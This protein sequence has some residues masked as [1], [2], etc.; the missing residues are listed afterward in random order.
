MYSVWP[1]LTSIENTKFSWQVR[2]G[3]HPL[4]SL[5]TIHP[6]QEAEEFQDRKN[7]RA[8]GEENMTINEGFPGHSSTDNSKEEPEKNW[9][10]ILL[11]QHKRNHMKNTESKKVTIRHHTTSNHHIYVYNSTSHWKQTHQNHAK[12]FNEKG[13]NSKNIHGANPKWAWRLQPPKGAFSAFSRDLATSCR[14][15]V[16]LRQDCVSQIWSL[17]PRI[18]LMT[19]RWEKDCTICIE[20]VTN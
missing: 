19:Q 16:D 7:M 9:M 15:Q 8:N 14:S 2:C 10:I 13:D 20:L 11:K 3:P 18:S 4:G 17:K 5:L 6:T 12:T 1:Q